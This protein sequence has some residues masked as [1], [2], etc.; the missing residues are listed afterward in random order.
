[1]GQYIDGGINVAEQA[2][3]SKVSIGIKLRQLRKM[4][5]I[6]L[7]QL[8]EETGMSY[9]YLSG[10]ENDKHSISI[11]TLQ[12]LADFFDVELI[13]FLDTSEDPPVFLL[14]ESGKQEVTQ[15]G[16]L[17]N[18]ITAESAKNMKVSFVTMPPNTPN[19]RQVIRGEKGEEF[20]SVLEGT[21]IF[22]IEGK[23]YVLHQG[24]SVFF[25]S[26]REHALFTEAQPA[27]IIQVST[28][29]NGRKGLYS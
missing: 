19:E 25:A 5:D 2:G 3:K 14:E 8:A 11:S 7:Q 29:P 4:R 1:M 27:R 23:R 17:V 24:D 12:R 16:I 18:L 20:I 15:D 10:L 21:L 9:S 26:E 28:P 6:S 22:L 13:H